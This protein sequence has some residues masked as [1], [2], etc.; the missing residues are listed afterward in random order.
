[1]FIHNKFEYYILLYVDDIARYGA[2]IPHLT[3]LIK[4]VPTAFEISDLGEDSFLHGL[5]ITYTS[6]GIVFT[7]ESYIGTILYVG[8]EQPIANGAKRTV[9]PGG[10]RKQVSLSR[11]V[12][13]RGP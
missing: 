1:M 12:L 7:Q 2:D 11:R 9:L 8:L 13:P 5:H 10:G 3:T 6:E 4:D